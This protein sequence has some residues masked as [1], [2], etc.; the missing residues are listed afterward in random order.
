MS[1]VLIVWSPISTSIIFQPHRSCSQVIYIYIYI[2]IYIHI[3]IYLHLRENTT[4][5]LVGKQHLFLTF[6][7]IWVPETPATFKSCVAKNGYPQMQRISERLGLSNVVHLVGGFNLPLWKMM[8]FVS[9]DS[10][11]Y[12]GK[13][14]KVHGSSHH[15][16]VIDYYINHHF[17]HG[18]PMVFPWFSQ[19]QSYHRPCVFVIEDL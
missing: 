18:F 14:I 1:H 13:V 7:E 17:F 2:Y 16:P 6:A 10:S 15:Q 8:D 4:W 19:D 12:D 9:W 3:Y 5:F 11:Q